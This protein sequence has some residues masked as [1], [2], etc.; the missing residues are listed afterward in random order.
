ME[1]KKKTRK[2]K[3]YFENQV[4]VSKGKYKVNAQVRFIVSFKGKPIDCYIYGTEKNALDAL[5]R[6]ESVRK[7][8][9]V[10]DNCGDII[11]EK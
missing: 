10:C 4:V 7:G 11:K 2:K 9:K 5:K 1:N 6:H 8:K 3:T